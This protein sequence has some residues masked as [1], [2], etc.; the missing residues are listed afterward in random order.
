MLV[1]RIDSEVG[2]PRLLIDDH[3]QL[4]FALAQDLT[5]VRTLRVIMIVAVFMLEMSGAMPVSMMIVTATGGA[6]LGK[7]QQKRCN[8]A[9]RYHDGNDS[10]FSLLHFEIAFPIA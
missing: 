2:R 1:E 4:E 5:A 10:E 7:A 9:N 6:L 3:F 8:S